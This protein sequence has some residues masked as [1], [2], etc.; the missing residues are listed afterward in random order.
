LSQYNSCH[1]TILVTIEFDLVM[2]WLWLAGSIKSYVSFAK[3]PYKRGNI[4]QKRPVILSILL[5]VATPY[6]II[7]IPTHYVSFCD[8]LN[9]KRMVFRYTMYSQL[10][11]AWHRI[12]RLFLKTFDLVP[13]V[14]GFSGIHHLLHGTNRK[15][16]GQNFGS[17]EFF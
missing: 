5:T 14:P 7:C 10:R 6:N 1:N 11:I 2:G 12:L 16:H 3:E 17:L 8:T 13:G 4:L 15:S 9:Q